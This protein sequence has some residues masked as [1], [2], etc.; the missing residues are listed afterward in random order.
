MTPLRRPS[1]SVALLMTATTAL[2]FFLGMITTPSSALTL[3]NLIGVISSSHHPQRHL[4][5]SPSQT[6][7]NNNNPITLT[8]D[9]EDP[10]GLWNV[11]SSSRRGSSTKQQQQQRRFVRFGFN[12]FQVGRQRHTHQVVGGVVD[13][14]GGDVV[15]QPFGPV[16][17]GGTLQDVI[18]LPSSSSSASAF[19][20]TRTSSSSSSSSATAA[21]SLQAAAA[22]SSTNN[23]NRQSNASLWSNVQTTMRGIRHTIIHSAISLSG[24]LPKTIIEEERRSND[25]DHHNI[26]GGGLLFRMHGNNN[27]HNNNLFDRHGDG[28]AVNNMSVLRVGGMIHRHLQKSRGW[29]HHQQRRRG[30][31]MMEEV[32]LNHDNNMAT[33]SN[34]VLDGGGFDVITAA[35]RGGDASMTNTLSSSSTLAATEAATAAAGMMSS[36]S[37]VSSFATSTSNVATETTFIIDTPL[38]PIILP[39]SWEAPFKGTS[40]YSS[41]SSSSRSSTATTSTTSATSTSSSYIASLEITIAPPE[42]ISSSSTTTT[43][44]ANKPS[45]HQLQ[46]ATLPLIPKSTWETFTGNEFFFPQTYDGLVS[47]GVLMG[48]TVMSA[49]YVNWSGEKKT[50]KFLKDFCSIS[51]DDGGGGGSASS[52]YEALDSSQ[53]VLV[54]SGKFIDST[55]DKYGSELPIIKTTSIIHKSPKYLAELLMDSTKVKAYNK[56]S[57][58]RDDVQVFQTGVDTTEEEGKFGNVGESKIVRNLTRPPMVNSNLEFVSEYHHHIFCGVRSFW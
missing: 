12:F 11:M 10:S 58:G 30:V 37:P 24:I 25:H 23:N 20:V 26:G 34:V 31:A 50:E 4:R 19:G 3:P 5:R 39:K 7:R 55:K 21:L 49:E 32:Y 33:S 18:L 8:I 47:T 41:S 48:S 56:M 2:L 42:D 51:H 16:P 36:S 28:A 52:W 17:R 9:D 44:G 38:F 1:S 40:S 27:N 14:S 54:W 35:P 13:A 43:V 46:A 57:L 29:K 15:P 45:P 22:A 6:S 53:E